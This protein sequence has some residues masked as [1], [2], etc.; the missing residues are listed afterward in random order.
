MDCLTFHT[1]RWVATGLLTQFL[2]DTIKI[3]TQWL[4]YGIAVVLLFTALR[5]RAGLRFPL[6]A[7]SR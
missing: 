2:K 1:M 6:A 4:P 5:L 7:L 3:H